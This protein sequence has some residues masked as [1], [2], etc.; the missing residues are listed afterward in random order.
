M[1]ILKSTRVCA[2]T[3]LKSVKKIRSFLVLGGCLA[4]LPFVL[5]YPDLATEMV[6]FGLAV[7][8]FDLLVGYMG[9]LTFCQSVYF[10]WAAYATGLIL[11]HVVKDMWL[12]LITAIASGAILGLLTGFLSIQRRG[13]YSVLISYALTEVAF[14][15]AFH[16][17]GLTG[18]DDGMGVPRPPLNL[19]F[20]SIDLSSPLSFYIFVCVIFM[21]CFAILWKIVSSPFGRVLRGIRENEMRVQA[22]GFN[23]QDFKLAAF[24]LSGMFTGLAG[25]LYA[26]FLQFA[27][28]SFVAFDT[29][30]KIVMMTLLGGAGSL[31]GPLIGAAL[32]TILSDLLSAIWARWMLLLGILFVIFV[33]YMR[34]G[35]WGFAVSVIDYL[36]FK[37][38]RVKSET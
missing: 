5:P 34:G 26:M 6:L 35:I 4:L 21:I 29:S 12:G 1:D 22:I 28:I 3:R 7:V 11:G 23:V 19:G 18:G 13:T 16:F 33:L 20:L 17:K 15:F 37:M 10:G 14:F 24:V 31:Y 8:A 32:V 38:T 9:Q 36:R 25:S 30:A 27:H 2:Q